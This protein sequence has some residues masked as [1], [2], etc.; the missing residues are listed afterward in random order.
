LL[1]LKILRVEVFHNSLK[2]CTI[3]EEKEYTARML[4]QKAGLEEK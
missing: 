3:M 1:K 2:R 4:I